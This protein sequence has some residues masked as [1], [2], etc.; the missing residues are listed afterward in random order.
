[1]KGAA[2]V[3]QLEQLSGPHVDTGTA[4]SPL[5]SPPPPTLTSPALM[6]SMRHL[7]E[8]AETVVARNFVVVAP[9]HVVNAA[10]QAVLPSELFVQAESISAIGASPKGKSANPRPGIC[11][12]PTKAVLHALPPTSEHDPQ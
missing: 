2:G 10:W 6:P 9:T 7:A 8:S 3:Q 5:A 12:V 11:S 1:M 4:P